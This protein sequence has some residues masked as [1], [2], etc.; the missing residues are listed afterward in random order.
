VLAP[1]GRLAIFDGD[2]VAA[3][4]GWSDST[5]G[6]AVEEALLGLLATSPRVVRD[7]PRLLRQAG[8][9]I[10]DVEARLVAE[11]GTGSQIA[12]RPEVYGPLLVE[13]GALPAALVE[14]WVAEQRQAVQDGTF[15]GAT[16]YYAYIARH[17]DASTNT[18]PGR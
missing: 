7:L 14:R 11:V 16:P 2:Y 9:A 1:H 5:L 6:K 13:C 4:F 15:F 3:G 8:M 10:V 12:S 17:S 18:T